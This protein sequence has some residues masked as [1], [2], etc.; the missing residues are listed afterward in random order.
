MLQWHLFRRAAGGVQ[1]SIL[2]DESGTAA[3]VLSWTSSSDCGGERCANGFE[4]LRGIRVGG[5]ECASNLVQRVRARAR[6]LTLR[7]HVDVGLFQFRYRLRY[8]ILDG[9]KA[10]GPSLQ[11]IVRRSKKT[12]E[13]G[14]AGG[15][16]LD[17]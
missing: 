1:A 8:L 16:S 5:V 14:N 2:P 13:L 3:L 17:G 10:L 6:S 7:V 12:L 11:L 15:I 4:S 9:L